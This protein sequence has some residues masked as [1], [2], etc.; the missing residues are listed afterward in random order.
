M[1]N[2]HLRPLDTTI[3]LNRLDM[4]LEKL[5]EQYVN[6]TY[7]T[8]EDVLE[9]FNRAVYEFYSD[10]KKPF[11]KLRKVHKGTSPN[12]I[13]Y[14]KSFDEIKWDLIILFRELETLEKLVLRN[15]NF[16]VSERDK[17]VKLLKRINSKIGDYG[18]Y[19]KD[20]IGK[21]IYFKDSFNNVSLIDYNSPLLAKKQCQIFQAEGIIT[22]PMTDA[23][24]S[25]T[26]RQAHIKMGDGS[27][28]DGSLGNQHE[29]GVA[30]RNRLRD[31]VDGN[32]DTWTEFERVFNDKEEVEDALRWDLIVYF[33][34]PQV[35]N[36]IKINPNNFGT[37]IPVTIKSIDTSLD[38][39]IW[40]SIKD[41]IPI[42]GFL[43][44][45][46]EDIFKLAPST[47]KYA[48]QGLYTFTPRKVKYVYICLEQDAVYS[49]QTPA[50]EKWRQA[51]GIRDIELHALPFET[52]GEII[53]QPFVSPV[54]IKKVALLASENPTEAS[55]LADV[56]HQVSV[57]D[58]ATWY[59]IQPQDRSGTE[60][61]EILNFNNDVADSIDTSTAVYALRHR[62]VLTR[63]PD[64]FKEGSST[65]S[66]IVKNAV[67]VLGIPTQSPMKLLLSRPP[68]AGTVKIMNP[69][70]GS[71]AM[72]GVKFMDIQS[73]QLSFSLPAINIVGISTGTSGMSWVLPISK[74]IENGTIDRDDVVIW[75][76]NDCGWERTN[77]FGSGEDK[78]SKKYILTSLGE[79]IFGTQEVD[80]SLQKGYIPAAGSRIG[81]TLKEDRLQVTGGSPY[82]C[83]LKMP[84]DGSKEN[85][86]I[87]RIGSEE[88]ST[89][90]IVPGASKH[91]LRNRFVDASSMSFS[92]DTTNV[93]SSQKT[94]QDG[95]TELV[96][97]GDY[98]VDE[99]R[100]VVYSFSTTPADEGS[101]ITVTYNHTPYVQLS[102]TDWDFQETNNDEFRW[103]IIR[104]N[105]YVK[106][107]TEFDLSGQSGR[108]INLAASDN[109][110]IIRIVPKSI[111]FKGD[112]FKNGSSNITEVQ[113]ID[114][115]TEFTKVDSDISTE[116]YFS[117]DYANNIMYISP[118]DELAT[119]PGSVEYEYTTYYATY[120]IARYI[121]QNKFTVDT[122]AK[123]ISIDEE[124]SLKVWG[125]RDAEVK[126]RSLLKAIYDYVHTTRE[127]IEELE[128]FFTPIVRDIA[129]KALP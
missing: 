1:F 25:N 90:N 101:Q 43:Q 77:E 47:S 3:F 13:D 4:L 118:E 78:Y 35:V 127:S 72:D 86:K 74:E 49:I 55:E 69:L 65:L 66:T 24:A 111:K 88:S 91:V 52:E 115:I 8:R 5:Q 51:I 95:S 23:S 105:A 70:W 37:Q 84:S 106:Y 60:I 107:K 81:F 114:G 113:F 18:L 46:E 7:Q 67:D 87:Y 68:V 71:V 39:S 17:L 80:P 2:K 53:S 42:A 10:L 33:D 45:D 26:R 62:M 59:D 34:D 41:D 75:V 31:I 120:N 14:N 40:T 89:D 124:E 96:Y 99:L 61:S 58:G 30:L 21:T 29:V 12:Y 82:L 103:I 28:P 9:E 108:K 92:G 85:V 56:R 128:P 98:S 104:D 121:P 97:P 83:Q 20:P 110:G 102:D 36:F 19:T 112:S 50:G 63:N 44:E 129:I 122:T 38:G 48:G 123:T 15:F 11:L 109:M 16:M 94:F 93:F 125:D 119:S 126:R 73:N 6:G 76:D 116:G 54:E 100:G 22:L 57:D 79:L 32:P 27:S 117:V 64:K